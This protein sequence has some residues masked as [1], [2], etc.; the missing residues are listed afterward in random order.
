MDAE[1]IAKDLEDVLFSEPQI[2]QRVSELAAEIERDYTG[3][4]AAGESPLFVGVLTG[5]TYF[6][7]DLTRAIGF[8]TEVHWLALSS[9]GAGTESSGEIIVLKELSVDIRGRD[10]VVVED[11]IDTGLTLDWLINHLDEAGARSVRV[12]ALLRKPHAAKVEVP[13]HYLGFD[14]ANRF[15]VGYGLDYAEQYR[16]L[17]EI[18]VLH[19]GAIRETPENQ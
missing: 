19:P 2:R 13:A 4:V 18:A 7:A 17:R 5:A 9:Y 1:Q 16:N 10:V 12:C 14:I 8:H 15:V 6:M 11:I 3:Q